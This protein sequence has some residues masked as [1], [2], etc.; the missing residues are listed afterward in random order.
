MG[1]KAKSWRD[2]LVARALVR[3]GLSLCSR[4]LQCP[5]KEHPARQA[6]FYIAEGIEHV[7]EVAEPWKLD[8]TAVEIARKWWW[9]Q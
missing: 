1:Q 4:D 9:G 5:P 6:A 3:G 2:L 8:Q 7:C